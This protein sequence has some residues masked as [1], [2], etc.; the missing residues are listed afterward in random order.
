MI[1]RSVWQAGSAD[2]P[3]SRIDVGEEA[4]H[5]DRLVLRHF[6]AVGDG[7][8][9]GARR[10]GAGRGPR[11]L[12][13]CRRSG[14][15]E[16]RRSR[17]AAGGCMVATTSRSTF[18]GPGPATQHGDMRFPCRAPRYAA[19]RVRVPPSGIA[20]S[21]SRCRVLVVTIIYGCMRTD[22]GRFYQNCS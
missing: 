13:R 9:A 7:A 21:A 22:T 20:R 3:L 12:V 11:W 19:L 18:R 17:F 4:G 6:Q 2:T 8:R 14:W 5:G 15:P 10:R 16:A 1:G